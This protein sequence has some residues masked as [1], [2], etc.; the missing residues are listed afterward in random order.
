MS[1]QL[2]S[3]RW[4]ALGAVLVAAACSND[5]QQNNTITGARA[6]VS[7][8]AKVYT[9]M[10][11]L[12]NPLVSEVT[13][14]KARHDLYNIGQ[15][16]TDVGQFFGDVS[17]FVAN[18]AG[19]GQAYGDAIAAALLPDVLIVYPTRVNTPVYWL[20]WV[21]GGYGGRPLADDVVDTGLA[22]IF[23]SLLGNNNNVSPGL[24]TDNV[25]ANDVAFGTTFPY[26][27]TA[28]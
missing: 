14:V 13:V 20:S 1:T 10:D 17:G 2:F 12:G 9:Q 27:A 4:I 11:R 18:T 24:T 8:A 5:P 19:R 15:P 21:F 6:A 7:G 25:P 3:R 22:A 28:H 23:G 26:L 16:S